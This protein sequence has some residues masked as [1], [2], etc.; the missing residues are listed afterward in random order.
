[1]QNMPSSGTTEPPMTEDSSE[2]LGA[3]A[4]ALSSVFAVLVGIVVGVITT[5]T[6][7]L[8]A[9]W[10]LVVGLAIVAALIGGFRLVFGSRVVGA[11]AALGIVGAAA[12]LALPGAGGTVLTLDGVSGWVWALGPVVIALIVLLLPRGRRA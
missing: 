7:S 6:H 4:T 9:P 3:G 2:P 10:G 5:F 11:A 1:M 8:L 12:A